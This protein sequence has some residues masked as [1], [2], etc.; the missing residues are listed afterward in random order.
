MDASKRNF[1]KMSKLPYAG[2][3]LCLHLMVAPQ[4]YCYEKEAFSR[5]IRE[6]CF[7]LA[8]GLR[9]SVGLWLRSPQGASYWQLKHQRI[10][11]RGESVLL[12]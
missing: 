1:I 9:S 2:Q 4:D 10:V 11:N 5:Y 8:L 7:A 3:W 6:G 12:G